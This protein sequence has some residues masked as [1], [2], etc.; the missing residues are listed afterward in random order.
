MP[1]RCVK[2]KL[3]DGSSVRLTEWATELNHRV[4]EVRSSLQA[5]GVSLEAAFLDSQ[6][7]GLY[8]IYVMHADDLERA[9]TVAQQSNASI[10]AYH[11]AFAMTCWES[12]HLLEPLIDFACEPARHDF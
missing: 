6:A 3:K 7:D 1:T 8:L 2:I 9:K 11:R 5:E 12:S 4:D 10:D